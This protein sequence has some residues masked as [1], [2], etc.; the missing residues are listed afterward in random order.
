M[1]ENQ[2]LIDCAWALSQI[3]AP[4]TVRT[5]C[6]QDI[7]PTLVF[8]LEQK[9]LVLLHPV[10]RIVGTISNATEDLCQLI[11]DHGML[12]RFVLLLS[13]NS[14]HIKKEVMWIVSNITAGTSEQIQNVMDNRAL[15]AHVMQESTSGDPEV[16]FL[17]FGFIRV[18][19]LTFKVK[20]E[21]VW[22]LCNVTKHM[23]ANQLKFLLGE[24]IL[25][26]FK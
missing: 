14:K 6:D 11:I 15:F 9:P 26:L 25:Q 5:I 4:E 13:N 2:T 20:R 7:I 12:E 21:A 16:G 8:L 10:L 22:S 23:S 17:F 1:S 24:D 3:S 19:F 18:I